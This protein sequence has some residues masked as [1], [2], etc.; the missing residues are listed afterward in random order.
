MRWEFVHLFFW[1]KL[2]LLVREFSSGGRHCRVLFLVVFEVRSL[3]V[4]AV[5]C[6]IWRRIQT[7]L[8]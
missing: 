2:F 5:C 7:I 4:G 8:I 6:R 1:N 3:A